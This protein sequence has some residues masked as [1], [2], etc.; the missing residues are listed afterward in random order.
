VT[1]EVVM[2]IPS[3]LLFVNSLMKILW[4]L[5]ELMMVF[6]ITFGVIIGG[7]MGAFALLGQLLQ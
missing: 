4:D 2:L 6:V 1:V 5:F 7:G 3:G